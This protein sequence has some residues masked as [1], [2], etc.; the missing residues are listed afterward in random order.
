MNELHRISSKQG[1][2]HIYTN[3]NK[4]TPQHI[5]QVLN[6]KGIYR[7]VVYIGSVRCGGGNIK[8][9]VLLGF[10]KINE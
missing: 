10:L 6:I 4:W 8:K 9:L 5:H 1:T 2:N 7:C 3:L